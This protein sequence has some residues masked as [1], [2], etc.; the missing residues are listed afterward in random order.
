[1]NN[2]TVKV[3][4]EE[5]SLQTALRASERLAAE[6]GLTKNL[7]KKLRK[8]RRRLYGKVNADMDPLTTCL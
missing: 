4:K 1:M 7:R 8:K 5:L 3:S 6:E 2:Q